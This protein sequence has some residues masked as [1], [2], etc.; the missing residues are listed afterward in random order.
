MR[1]G[2][3]VKGEGG[4]YPSRVTCVGCS[5]RWCPEGAG[6]PCIR[7]ERLWAER[8]AVV[9]VVGT[10]PCWVPDGTLHVCDEDADSGSSLPG[11][12]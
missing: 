3:V 12:D 1:G 2:G 7:R 4:R 6:R 8:V 5:Y 9:A 10:D 11:T